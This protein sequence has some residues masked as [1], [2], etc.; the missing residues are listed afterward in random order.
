MT[1]GYG[2]QSSSGRTTPDLP[3]H[4][5][6]TRGSCKP[7]CGILGCVGM[8]GSENWVSLLFIFFSLSVFLCACASVFSVYLWSALESLS[9]LS[10][11]PT[12]S[13]ACPMD[14]VCARLD[15]LT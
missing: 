14:V 12:R 11:M 1:L 13:R 9:V 10:V 8:F 7:S 4:T 6:T 3:L 15:N 5:L 2:Y